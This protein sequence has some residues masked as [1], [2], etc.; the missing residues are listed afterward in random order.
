M[1]NG[2]Y[3]ARCVIMQG[4]AR[5][6]KPRI[7]TRVHTQRHSIYTGRVFR[8]AATR[9]A[10]KALGDYGNDEILGGEPPLMDSDVYARERELIASPLRAR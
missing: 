4:R 1:Y 3:A 6:I 5:L 10:H 7:C 8:D 2:I 9:G